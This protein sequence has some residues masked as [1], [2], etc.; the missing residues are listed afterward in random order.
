[1]ILCDWLNEMVFDWIRVLGDEI[2]G[3]SQTQ[4][5]EMMWLNESVFDWG[6]VLVEWDCLI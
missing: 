5:E 4:S 3:M 2:V 6:C 1:M